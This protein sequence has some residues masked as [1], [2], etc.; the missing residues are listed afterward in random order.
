MIFKDC[1]V[2]ACVPAK[3]GL[4]EINLCAKFSRS[5]I[6]EASEGSFA[7]MC[8]S[9]E[10]RPFKAYVF[11]EDHLKEKRI[12]AEG[13]LGEIHRPA[14]LEIRKVRFSRKPK[15]AKVE[16]LLDILV[17]KRLIK[18]CALLLTRKVKNTVM[19]A[20][21]FSKNGFSFT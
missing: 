20:F 2:E 21:M 4:A 9:L 19:L 12:S 17:M 6:S 8:S 10:N 18:S 13:R 16:V 11:S 3:A 7:E 1:T 5:E 14:K 15:A